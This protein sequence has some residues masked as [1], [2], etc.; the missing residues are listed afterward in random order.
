MTAAAQV[1]GDLQQRLRL[2]VAGPR[3]RPIR[4]GLWIAG[5]A[6]LAY[7]TAN[8]I[9]NGPAYDARAYYDAHLGS[10]YA[11]PGAGTFDAYYYSPAFAQLIA[12]LTALPWQL[13]IAIWMSIAALAL[14]YLSGPLIVLVLVFPPVVSELQVGNIH[15]LLGLVAALGIEYPALWAFALL[16]KVTPGV[17]VLWFAVRREWRPLAIALGTT[18]MITAISFV[19]APSLWF[20]FLAALRANSGTSYEWPPLPIPLV[21]RLALGAALIA[22]GARTNR[23]WTVPVGATLALPLLW[24]ANWAMIVG[25]LPSVRRALA[26]RLAVRP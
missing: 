22:W 6:Y 13:F 4:D 5:L 17:G 25:V 7:L 15:F 18:I 9:L 16:T 10:L 11:R 23:R 1:P 2:F 8:T 19:L 24:P 21:V 26:A 14:A 20:D 3:W 12:P